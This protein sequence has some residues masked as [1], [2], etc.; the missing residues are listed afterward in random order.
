MSD[1]P[2]LFT[3]PICHR[4]SWNPHDA[5]ERFCGVCGYVD[6]VLRDQ[7]FDDEPEEVKNQP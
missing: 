4:G 3:C 7:R 1:T 6:D 5:E 2:P